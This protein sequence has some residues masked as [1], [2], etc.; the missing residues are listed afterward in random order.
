MGSQKLQERGEVLSNHLAEFFLVILTRTLHNIPRVHFPSFLFNSSCLLHV[1]Q[2]SAT[3]GIRTFHHISQ[4]QTRGMDGDVGIAVF[5]QDQ[6]EGQCTA[7]IYGRW[8]CG[9]WWGVRT[10][11]RV[12]YLGFG[13]EG[14]NSTVTF[15]RPRDLQP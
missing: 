15:I 2:F 12:W 14:W 5:I 8:F 4:L 1:N 11:C 10:Y 13:L 3:I 7:S 9:V 6:S